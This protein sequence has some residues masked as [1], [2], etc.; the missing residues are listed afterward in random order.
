MAVDRDRQHVRPLVE[1][2]LLAVA[3]MVVDVEH[4]DF[5]ERRQVMGRDGRVVEVAEAAEGLALG[6]MAGRADERIGDASA[7][8]QLLGSGQRAIDGTP[9]RAERRWR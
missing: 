4:G 1:D 5:A 3:V 2:V 8:E 9:G 6:V 7:G